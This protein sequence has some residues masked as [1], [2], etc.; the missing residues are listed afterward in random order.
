MD[1]I[2][3]SVLTVCLIIFQSVIFPSFSFFHQSFDILLIVVLLISISSVHNS[4]IVPVIIIGWIM[5]SISGVIFFLN[6]FSYLFIYMLIALIKRIIFKQSFFF[7]IIISFLAVIIQNCII[8]FSVFVT[9]GT[10]A[11]LAL[12]YALIIKQ[13]LWGMFFIPPAVFFFQKCQKDLRLV[14]KKNKATRHG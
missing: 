1:A 7:I 2:F 14:I 11:V 3:I 8:I 12:N 13:A 9:Q 6:I 5:D 10:E 4:M